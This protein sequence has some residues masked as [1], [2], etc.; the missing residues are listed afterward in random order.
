MKCTCI[1]LGVYFLSLKRPHSHIAMPQRLFENSNLFQGLGTGDFAC[2]L[3][4]HV[5]IR[6]CTMVCHATTTTI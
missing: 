2:I 6:S 5:W 3:F 1:F 4:Y